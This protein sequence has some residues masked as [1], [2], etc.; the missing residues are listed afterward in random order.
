MEVRFGRAGYGKFV[1]TGIGLDE[2]RTKELSKGV[3]N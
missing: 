2:W 3:G 1:G